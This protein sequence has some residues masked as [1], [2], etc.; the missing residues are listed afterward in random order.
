MELPEKDEA[1]IVL[2]TF[3]GEKNMEGHVV[4]HLQLFT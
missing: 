1:F 2:K 4:F 3:R